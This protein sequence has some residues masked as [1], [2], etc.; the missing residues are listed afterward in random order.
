MSFDKIFDL[1]AGVYLRFI[2][3]SGLTRCNNYTRLQCSQSTIIG[4]VFY[5]PEYV[6]KRLVEVA[7]VVAT[8]IVPH[9]VR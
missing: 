3:I 9:M 1:T 5:C 4:H 8:D 6:P 2:L 7:C